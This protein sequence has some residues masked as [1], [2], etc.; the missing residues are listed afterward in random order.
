M[1]ASGRSTANASATVATRCTAIPFRVRTRRSSSAVAWSSS[2]NNTGLPLGA[3]ASCDAQ[4][5]DAAK[6][7]ALELDRSGVVVDH[8]DVARHGPI[9]Y[10]AV[11]FGGLHCS[12]AGLIASLG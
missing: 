10:R 8:Q 4:M 7:A 1:N 5:T 12:S 3:A 6:D 9:R 2:T 11:T